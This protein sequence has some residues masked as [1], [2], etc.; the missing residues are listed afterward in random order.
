MWFGI[1]ITWETREQDVIHFPL[2]PLR[3]THCFTKVEPVINYIAL[4]LGG[5]I[6]KKEKPGLKLK[7]GG[8]W[9]TSWAIITHSV[10]QH[11]V[12]QQIRS[13]KMLIMWL[14]QCACFSPTPLLNS[15]IGQPNP[16]EG[17]GSDLRGKIDPCAPHLDFSFWLLFVSGMKFPLQSK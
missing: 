1:R 12:L 3:C 6:F 10:W 8:S 13:N 15:S 9:I 16:L 5:C 2:R 14:G 4:V 17:G 11:S 7:K